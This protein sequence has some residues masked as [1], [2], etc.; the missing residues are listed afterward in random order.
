MADA[1]NLTSFCHSSQAP[2]LFVIPSTKLM[3]WHQ[4]CQTV[5]WCAT[6]RIGLDLGHVLHGESFWLFQTQFGS[7]V[8]FCFQRRT[9]R[10]RRSPIYSFDQPASLQ[11]VWHIIHESFSRRARA[12]LRELLLFHWVLLGRSFVRL[13]KLTLRYKTFKRGHTIRN[14][15]YKKTSLGN[16]ERGFWI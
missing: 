3:E 7:D 15:P 13:I 16:Y 1:Q 11:V 10:R 5:L 2:I 6:T 12:D 9:R 4:G 14:E 8:I